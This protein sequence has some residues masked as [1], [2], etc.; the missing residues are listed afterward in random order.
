MAWSMGRKRTVSTFAIF[1]VP[2][3]ERGKRFFRS[4]TLWHNIFSLV[5]A[6]RFVISQ[7]TID[8]SSI[9]ICKSVICTEIASIPPGTPA[10]IPENFLCPSVPY[11]VGIE[12]EGMKRGK[13]SCLSKASK[14][15]QADFSTSQ[16][17]KFL[18]FRGWRQIGRICRRLHRTP[19]IS[20]VARCEFQEKIEN[21]IRSQ[22]SSSTNGC[23]DLNR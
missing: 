15:E 13:K 17:S 2:L 20:M 16:T 19:S 6:D 11:E 12:N 8:V 18:W 23:S 22:Q 4:F 5:P 7:T 14:E 3:V 1:H 9:L 10:A 21:V